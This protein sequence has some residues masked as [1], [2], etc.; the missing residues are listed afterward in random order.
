MKS[1]SDGPR[2]LDVC[3]SAL[4]ELAAAFFCAAILLLHGLTH[5]S[6]A[7]IAIR[8]AWSRATPK[9]A[10][11]AAGYLTIE[12]RA[13][14]ADK[15]LSASTPIAGKTEIHEML[16]H[17]GVMK[18]RPIK[19]GLTIPPNGKL[20]F[21]PGGRHLM[22]V[23]LR[24]PLVE[25]EQV[26]VSLEF[27]KAGQI[28]ISLQV[29][30]IGAKGPQPSATSEGTVR[31]TASEADP[32]FTHI[33]DPRVMA[34]VT[35]SPGRSGA[36]EVLVQL[37]DSQENA[38]VAEGLSVTLTVPDSGSAPI[39]TSAERIASDTWR[40]QMVVSEAGRWDLALQIAMTAE[41]KIEIAAPILIE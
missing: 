23:E 9:G 26:P 10:Q 3:V 6:A 36:V 30:G 5:A 17:G 34:N 13:D 39:F 1:N 28:D 2:E 22:F 7:D 29:A 40:A 18:M 35:V 20:T 14:S 31:A 12:N 25:G 38:L 27:E 24:S 41:D 11:V 19:D 8:Q 37:E 15:L 21:A 16:E 32:F 33:H 4:R